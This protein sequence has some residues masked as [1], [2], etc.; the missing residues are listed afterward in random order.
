MNVIRLQG[1]ALILSAVC[2]LLLGLSDPRTALFDVISTIGV[3]LFILGIPAVYLA[4][5]TGRAGLVGIVFLEFAALIALGFRF[6]L[7][8]SSLEDSLSLTSAILG[9]LGGIMVGWLT[10][11]EGVFPAWVGWIFLAQGLLNLIAGLFDFGSLVRMLL[12]VLQVIALIAYG[13]LI[14]RNNKN[15]PDLFQAVKEKGASD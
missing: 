12:P 11:R 8:P 6:E 14:Y 13:Y 9:T 4:Q 15:E 5:R 7:V 2:F 10:I 3:I 1:L